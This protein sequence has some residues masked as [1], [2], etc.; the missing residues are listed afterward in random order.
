MNATL[1]CFFHVKELSEYL[2]NDDNINR[3][4]QLTFVYKD[5]L[6]KLVGMDDKRKFLIRQKNKM[7]PNNTKAYVEPVQ[8]KNLISQLNKLFKGVTANDSKDLI[9]FLLENMDDELEKISNSGYLSNNG[10]KSTIIRKLFYFNKIT[11]YKCMNCNNVVQ[12]SEVHNLI[13]L[14]IEKIYYSLNNINTN[15]TA[16]SNMILQKQYGNYNKN[17]YN[18]L[19]KQNFKN[20]NQKKIINLIDCFAQMEK[21]ELLSG[22]NQIFCNNCHTS[23]NAMTCT[24]IDKAPKVLILVLNRG[25]GNVFECDVNFDEKLNLEK[26]VSNNSPKYYELIGV[27][28]HLGESSMKGH[29]IACC[30]HFDGNWYM[31]NDSI[32]K[33]TNDKKM[34]TPY[35]LFYQEINPNNNYT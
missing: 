21:A 19:Y 16:F 11:F 3:N 25:K 23:S 15:T 13:I 5:L 30:K 7:L 35:I 2:L 33:H 14:P 27:I 17:N 34:G 24:K 20:N 6:K 29:F 28:S 32:V 8:F 22:S 4:L 12:N 18:N 1:Q 10:Q 26:F 9:I 31:F